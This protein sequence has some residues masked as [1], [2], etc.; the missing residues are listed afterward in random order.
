MNQA[1]GNPDVTFQSS[2]V[3]DSSTKPTTYSPDQVRG[4]SVTDPLSQSEDLPQDRGHDSNVTVFHPYAI[5]EPGEEHPSS[6]T[7][8]PALTYLED[9]PENW[10]ADLVNSMEDL[11]CYSDSGPRIQKRGKKRKPPPVFAGIP[12]SSHS[13]ATI[14]GQYDGSTLSPKRLRRRNKQSRENLIGIQMDSTPDARSSR[15]P[16]SQSSSMTDTSGVYTADELTTD[17]PMDID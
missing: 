8:L 13:G 11:H 14:D 10:Q 5:E 1:S 9:N 17:E 3:L 2:Y 16:S 4:G 15:S 12:H 6:S 7:S